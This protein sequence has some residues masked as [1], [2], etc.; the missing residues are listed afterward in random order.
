[1]KKL[2]AGF[3][4]MLAVACAGTSAFADESTEMKN[5]RTGSSH[6]TSGFDNVMDSTHTEASKGKNP[7]EHVLGVGVGGVV[8]A[9][10]TLHQAGA[11]VID[12]LTFW[13]PKKQ[14]LINPEKSS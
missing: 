8:A 14:P 4:V 12:I 6:M 3:M 9:R 11:G 10:K 1:M 5:L 2:T 7:G 13:I